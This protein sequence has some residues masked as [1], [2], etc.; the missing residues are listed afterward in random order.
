MDPV[1]E[2]GLARVLGAPRRWLK[3][4]RFG[5]VSSTAARAA[6]GMPSFAALDAAV[7]GM[8][9]ALFVPE[10]GLTAACSDVSSR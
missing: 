1:V 2:L 5:L 6:N 4:G 8:L 9:A 7:P 3:A 10:H